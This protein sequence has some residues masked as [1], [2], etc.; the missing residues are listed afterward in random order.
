MNSNYGHNINFTLFGESHG[1]AI[2]ITI[3][4]LPA[5]F[6]IDFNIIDNDLI[7]RQGNAAFNTKRQENVEYDIVSGFFKKKTTGQPMTVLFHNKDMIEDDY[8]PFLKQPRPGHA[9]IVA[10]KKYQEAN[11][12]RGGGHFSGRMTTPIV[13]LGS[14]IKQ[15]MQELF[16]EMKIVSHI[17]RLGIHHDISYY[18]YRKEVVDKRLST[19]DKLEELNTSSLAMLA[20]DINLKLHAKLTNSIKDVNFPTFSKE[21]YDVMLNEAKGLKC[22]TLGGLIETI[23]IN[24]PSWIGEPFFYSVESVLSS[25]L[26]SIPS[27]KGVRFGSIEGNSHYLGSE[28]KDEIIFANTHK[29][30]TLMNHNGGINGGITNGEDIVFST[31]IKP[32]A[33]IMG[34]QKTFNLETKTIESLIIEG[35]HDK[36][37]INRIIPVIDAMSYIT[38]YDLYLENK[39]NTL[40]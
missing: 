26:Y 20:L 35:R 19:L 11:D 17:K 32:I 3:N 8:F 31:I 5:N 37:I 1:K 36:T 30:T 38:L 18:D 24:P 21:A 7:L 23:I 6:E 39:K 10:A 22:D 28:L 4:N 29:V 12:F 15:I 40:F 2:G 34:E 9:D 13:F 14:I 16:S 27:V 25:L 33:S